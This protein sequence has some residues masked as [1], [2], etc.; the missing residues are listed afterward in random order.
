MEGHVTYL[1]P[2]ITVIAFLISVFTIC[3]LLVIPRI[4]LEIS[5][6]VNMKFT[7]ETF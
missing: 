1:V 7:F 5:Q 6:L 2:S 3:N 4:T